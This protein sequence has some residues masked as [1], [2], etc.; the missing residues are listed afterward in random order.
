MDFR[1]EVFMWNC[2]FTSLVT[3]LFR[4]RHLVFDLKCT[5]TRFDHFLS[6]Q[7]SRFF[8]TETSVDVRN[9]W[10]NVSLEVVDL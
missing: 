5:S 10:H 1:D 4:V 3:T 7:V 9:N 8:V 2:Y 6:K